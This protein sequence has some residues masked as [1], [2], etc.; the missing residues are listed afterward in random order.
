MPRRNE[1]DPGQRPV[2]PI[3]PG[4]LSRRVWEALYNVDPIPQDLRVDDIRLP[5]IPQPP[6]QIPAGQPVFEMDGITRARCQA[7]GIRNTL[8]SHNRGQMICQTVGCGRAGY[9]PQEQARRAQLEQRVQPARAVPGARINNYTYKPEPKFFGRSAQGLFFGIEHEVEAVNCEANDLATKLYEATHPPGLFYFKADASIHNGLEMVSH[10]MSFSYFDQHYPAEVSG[11]LKEY[12]SNT[13][14]DDYNCGIHLHMSRDA[15]GKFLPVRKPKV[16]RETDPVMGTHDVFYDHL[17]PS[18]HLT[19]FMQ[20]IYTH[21]KYV[22]TIAGRETAYSHGHENATYNKPEVGWWE[23]PDPKNPN[24]VI[25]DSDRF[26]REAAKGKPIAGTRYVAV[27]LQNTS[28]VELRIFRSTT[29]HRRLRAYVQFADALFYYSDKAKLYHR[30]LTKQ[31]S[32]EGF[33]A[34]VRA[35]PSRYADLIGVLDNDPDLAV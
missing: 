12:A 8:T 32:P 16:R 18:Y 24:R 31:M 15:F 23:Y 9:T 26:L 17:R 22:Q 20:F 35:H 1:E 30:N 33:D 10:P 25:R 27:N 34:Y 7:C 28:T 2:P 29:N 11:V 21:A 19:K 6:P 5:G 3:A 13:F 4:M 14:R